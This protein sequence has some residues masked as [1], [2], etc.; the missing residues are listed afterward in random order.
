MA[1]GS[2][3]KILTGCGIGCGGLLVLGFAVLVII[4]LVSPPVEAVA[5]GALDQA[6]LETLEANGYLEPGE[7]VLYF[8]T[9]GLWSIEENG[10]FFT[11]R[12]V[13][14]YEE[15]DTPATA[16]VARYAEIADIGIEYSDSW[17]DDSV[18]TVTRAGGDEFILLVASDSRGDRK[19]FNRLVSEWRKHRPADEPTVLDE[20]SANGARPQPETAEQQPAVSD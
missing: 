11:D 19:F 20:A 7:Q 10:N 15:G 12:K 13:V 2:G 14:A 6:Y 4:G 16:A 1:E 3:F 9:N 5:G 17:L 8:Y 18:I